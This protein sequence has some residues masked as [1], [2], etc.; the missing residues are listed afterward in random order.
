MHQKA[1]SSAAC[2]QQNSDSGLFV[3]TSA[4]ACTF[5]LRVETS[6]LAGPHTV[7]TRDQITNNVYLLVTHTSRVAVH[8]TWTISKTP[9]R[10]KLKQPRHERPR[11]GAKI[12]TLLFKRVAACSSHH[13]CQISSADKR[14]I[15]STLVTWL[16][17]SREHAVDSRACC[18]HAMQRTVCTL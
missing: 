14:P 16:Q 2:K 8:E 12:A 4:L 3:H 1:A 17:P 13:C 5:L 6:L 18:Q 11:N 7:R 9:A 15:V 10:T